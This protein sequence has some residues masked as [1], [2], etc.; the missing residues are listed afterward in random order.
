MD[1]FS[2]TY[3]LTAGGSSLV[4]RAPASGNISSSISS[5]ASSF[6]S[7]I[8]STTA[9]SSTSGLSNARINEFSLYTGSISAGTVRA[10]SSF[11]ISGTLSSFKGIISRTPA[12]SITIFSVNMPRFVS[13]KST[14]TLYG[15]DGLYIL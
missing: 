7:S 10:I 6:S 5:S 8:V 15:S 4:S 2:P 14:I 13:C 3:F 1:I 9:D 11:A 12:L